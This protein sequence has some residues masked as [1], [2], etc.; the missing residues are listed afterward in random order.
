VYSVYNDGFEES[1]SKDFSKKIKLEGI[2]N[3]D[4][5][6]YQDADYVKITKAAVEYSDAVIRGDENINPEIDKYLQS[7]KMPVLDY[8]DDDNYIKVYNELYDSLLTEEND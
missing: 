2:A 1:L 6:L 7:I 4:L 8:Q 5:T 3:K